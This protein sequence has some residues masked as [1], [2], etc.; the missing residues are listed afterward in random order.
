MEDNF[1]LSKLTKKKRV[2]SKQ[3]GSTFE[4]SICKQLNERF[5]TKE[6]SRTPGSG[7]FAT[8]HH[9]L[10]E[11]LKIYGDLITPVNFNFCIECK[12]GYNNIS[13]YSIFDYSSALWE[14]VEQSRKDAVKCGRIPM[15]VLKQDR[16]PTLAILPQFQAIDLLRNAEGIPKPGQSIF[17]GPLVIKEEK[18]NFAY[19]V[20]LFD[21]LLSS[22]PDSFWFSPET[23]S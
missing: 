1:D 14:F 7:A 3:K 23:S 22:T 8:T 2:N 6:F 9:N 21:E 4:R 18:Y 12:K 19:S 16:K 17:D 11:H 20:V 10:P 15:V 13:L 5:N